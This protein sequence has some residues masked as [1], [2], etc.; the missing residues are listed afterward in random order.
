MGKEDNSFVLGPS[1]VAQ[2]IVYPT[3]P[4]HSMHPTQSIIYPT[5]HT[6]SQS[7]VYPTQDII[8]ESLSEFVET[9]G[10]TAPVST[11]YT[12]PYTT[13]FSSSDIQHAQPIETT[14]HSKD[15]KDSNSLESYKEYEANINT[16]KLN[17]YSA[18]SKW[19]NKKIEKNS[20]CKVKVVNKKSARQEATARRQREAGEGKF[21]KAKV[22]WVTATDFFNTNSNSNISN[23]NTDS[24]SG[25]GYLDSM[26]IVETHCKLSSGAT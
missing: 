19:K 17:R 15:S 14:N 11:P 9:S 6:C 2:P 4:T 22:K 5:H 1:P 23:S 25:N 20:V 21:K 13:S 10:T 8:A 12:T 18:I 7:T 24:G 16:K 3:H 26:V